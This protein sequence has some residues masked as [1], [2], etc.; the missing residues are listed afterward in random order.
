MKLAKKPQLPLPKKQTPKHF[1]LLPI[2]LSLSVT[3]SSNCLAAGYNINCIC[4]GNI[5]QYK[6]C[7]ENLQNSKLPISFLVCTSACYKKIQFFGLQTVLYIPNKSYVFATGTGHFK[8]ANLWP[9]IWPYFGSPKWSQIIM[10][11]N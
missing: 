3:V 4:K 6:V 1:F 11:V 5:N 8:T 10:V 7:L 2:P 9:S